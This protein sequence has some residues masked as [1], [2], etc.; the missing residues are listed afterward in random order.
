MIKVSV[1]VPIY[2]V[3]AYLGD[4]LDSLLNQSMSDFEVILINDGSTDKS[5]DIIQKYKNKFNEVRVIS[6]SNKGLSF[7][8]N[9]GIDNARGEYI[10]FLDSDD[11]L[12]KNAL[13]ELFLMGKNYN[14]DV[15]VYDGIRID[16]ISNKIDKNVY[17]RSSFLKHGK[18]EKEEY[19]KS[20]KKKGM[21]HTPFHFYRS[22]FLRLNNIRFVENL[23]HEDELFSIITYQNMKKIGYCDRKFY[24]RRYRPN[25]IMSNKIYTNIKSLESY[26]Y[27]LNEFFKINK[28]T[29]KSD[30]E[31]KRLIE[32]RTKIILGNLIRYDNFTIKELFNRSKKYEVGVDYLRLLYNFFIYYIL[33]RGFINE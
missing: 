21:F 16:E 12:E 10:L 8:R 3:E 1:V 23:L 27:I 9:E 2:N 24:I 15:V 14:L 25:S 5:F 30:I 4:C 20:C 22:D 29:N 26:K 28:Q 7:S 18:L 19:F 31:L 33:K 17:S 13:E 32:W 11:M 6:R